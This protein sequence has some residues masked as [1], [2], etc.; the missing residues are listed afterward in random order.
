MPVTKRKL[1]AVEVLCR[2]GL[3]AQAFIPA[4]LEALHEVI[5]SRRN[6]FDWA[7]EDGRLDHYFVEGDLCPVVARRYFEDFH[8]RKEAECMPAFETL[9]TAPMGVRSAR[10]LDQPG[11]FESA[12]YHEIWKPQ[13][14]HTRLEGVVRGRSG[15][16]LGSLVLYRGPGDETFTN[17]DECTL[18]VLLSA[19]GRALESAST[20]EPGGAD[21]AFA[22]QPRAVEGVLLSSGG[23]ALHATAGAQ[24]LA[25]LAGD[26]LTIAGVGDPIERLLEC[27]FGSLLRRARRQLDTG[28]PMQQG[29]SSTGAWP[30]TPARPAVER[31]TNGYGR[32]DAFATPVWPLPAAGAAAEPMLQVTLQWAEPQ[33]AA[34]ARALR[35]LPITAGQMLVCDGLLRGLPQ[36]AIAAELGV[37][38]ATVVDHVRK[39][40]TALDV[41]STHELRSRVERCPGALH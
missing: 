36:P 3:P 28:R 35:Q 38:P 33:R 30:A 21:E 7:H 31:R 17:D 22:S 8:N 34:C 16:L 12:L 40:Y 2:L 25:L 15:R 1:A 37:S 4:M 24:R 9:R 19:I 20:P 6:L 39:V 32:F 13:G 14:L 41:G 29:S 23:Q 26:G 5:P 18:G 11:F 10:D 27:G